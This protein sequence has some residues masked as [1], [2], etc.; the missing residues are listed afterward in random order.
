MLYV[1]TRETCF[2]ILCCVKVSTAGTESRGLFIW[3]DALHAFFYCTSALTCVYFK[4]FN[5][6]Y[7]L[8]VL[9]FLFIK[10]VT[11]VQHSRACHKHRFPVLKS[12]LGTILLPGWWQGSLLCQAASGQ[13]WSTSLFLPTHSHIAARWP[14]V[15]SLLPLDMWLLLTTERNSYLR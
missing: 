5:C 6:C 7:V 10:A 11:T 8:S 4:H 1:C 14:K 12:H 9:E 13:P 3:W 15:F 2:S